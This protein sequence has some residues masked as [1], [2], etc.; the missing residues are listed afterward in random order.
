MAYYSPNNQ[1]LLSKKTASSS[2]LIEFTS[3]ITAAFTTYY[4]IFENIIPATDATTMT[5]YF[6]TDNGSTYLSSNYRW[7]NIYQ[8]SSGANTT[9]NN[10]SDTS[11]SLF[12]K[13]S[14]SSSRGVNGG[15]T[16]YSLN[17]TKIANYSGKVV[18][19]SSD[20][21]AAQNLFEGVNT[22]TTAVTAIK[23]QMSSGNITS[24]NIY[25]YGLLY[26]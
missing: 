9:N 12:N 13:V 16:L 14:N 11:L 26:N 21:A 5:M 23:F 7:A 18:H 19:Y 8:D 24:G 15:L 6:S 22:G 1:V 17:S 2:S 10:N 20:T 3:L 25:L 4:I